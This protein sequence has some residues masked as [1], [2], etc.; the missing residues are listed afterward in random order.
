MRAA[1]RQAQLR[2][3]EQTRAE[4]CGDE[5]DL[6]EAPH[7][8]DASHEE[9]DDDHGYDELDDSDLD[10]DQDDSDEYNEQPSYTLTDDSQPSIQ[11]IIK[12]AAESRAS[13][14]QLQ[15]SGTLLQRKRNTTRT[16]TQAHVSTTEQWHPSPEHARC[17]SPAMG[18]FATTKSSVATSTSHR[19]SADTS[20]ERQ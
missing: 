9:D 6:L 18:P 16:Q 10:S 17:H 3:S 12:T 11:N 14:L 4:S 13:K 2:I 20:F 7:L 5:D 19:S 1:A 15:L 8:R